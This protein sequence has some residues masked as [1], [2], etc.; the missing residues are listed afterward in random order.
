MTPA[1]IIILDAAM[2]YGPVIGRMVKDILNKPEPT[3]AEWDDLF[4]AM[5]DQRSKSYFDMVPDSKLP[6]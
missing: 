1:A 4:S 3:V 6:R 2:K 5:A